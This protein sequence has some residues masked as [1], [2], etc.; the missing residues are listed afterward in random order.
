MHLHTQ[1]LRTDHRFVCQQILQNGHAFTRTIANEQWLGMASHGNRQCY[2]LITL[3]SRLHF[4]IE[5]Q[6]SGS[7]LQRYFEAILY[8]HDVL[9]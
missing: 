8:T 2:C 3:K 9:S 1:L 6:V 4:L 5:L 7:L